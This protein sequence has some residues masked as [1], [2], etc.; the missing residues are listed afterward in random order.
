MFLT[1]NHFFQPEDTSYG[2]VSPA[3]RDVTQAR[4]EVCPWQ[5]QQSR[6][7]EVDALITL[8]L[9]GRIIKNAL[10]S[11][12]MLEGSEMYGND[13]SPAKVEMGSIQILLAVEQDATQG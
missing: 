10:K 9:N 13:S 8:D 12:Q 6:R 5:D 4:L 7:D 1:T 3:I 11:A 2:G